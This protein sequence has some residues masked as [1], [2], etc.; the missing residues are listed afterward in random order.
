MP[1]VMTQDS[2]SEMSWFDE[3]FYGGIEVP[4]ERS[5]RNHHALTLL[6]S[7]PPGT[8]KSTLALEMC[9]GLITRPK[10][11]KIL[12]GQNFSE[13]DPDV[14]EDVSPTSGKI[15]YVAS[16]ARPEWMIENAHSFGWLGKT[17]AST[18]SD[19]T[20][21]EAVL[22]KR[23][24]Q[25]FNLDLRPHDGQI[26]LCPLSLAL[27]QNGNIF[28]SLR[29]VLGLPVQPHNGVAMDIS[30]L[31]VVV[32]DSLNTVGPNK[33]KAYE[34]AYSAFVASG[35]SL[36]IF[37]LDSTQAPSVAEAWEF[38]ADI[39]LRLDKD[40][41]SGYMVRTLEV[42]K[43]RYQSHV[44]GK[45]NLKIHESSTR[46]DKP[47]VKQ[48]GQELEK[49]LRAHPWM[50]G[51]IFVF[52][53][54]HYILSRFKRGAPEQPGKPAIETPLPDLT[55]LLGGGIP[56][57][58]TTALIGSRGGHKSHLGHMQALYNV[59]INHG[60]SIIVSL[61]D[62]EAVVK[63]ALEKY[64][65]QAKWAATEDA[66]KSHLNGYLENGQLEIL[67]YMPGYVTPEEF[68][69]RMLLSIFRMR[70]SDSKKS[71]VLIFNSLDQIASRFPLCAK[72]KVLIPGIIQTLSH[73]GV[74]SIFIGADEELADESIRNLLSMAELIIRMKRV[75]DFP[76]HKFVQILRNA[77]KVV[78]PLTT[79]SRKAE[80]LKL[81]HEKKYSITELTVERFAGGKPAGLQGMLEL[82][83]SQSIFTGI[84]LPG[85][86]FIPY[87]K[88]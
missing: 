59:E 71:I 48:T 68:F 11:I 55:A 76:H 66:A 41:G 22:K 19:Y 8:G 56:A 49:R 14:S 81:G 39:V 47:E 61:R 24:N 37:V 32:I 44:W 26:A 82:V 52:P 77:H 67:S 21:K 88:L 74:T 63:R 34:D 45:N 80:L 27:K 73:L 15:L 60:L 50:E 78:R 4:K 51:G 65:F 5:Q 83:T 69:H 20:K 6:I 54:I 35:P 16:E 86:H 42:V 13:E 58:Y 62:G 53:S 10:N 36:M 2:A 28:E 1:G 29:R 87:R 72:E 84:L 75:D 43:A 31:D 3:L 7:G 40:Y 23:A 25:L 12:R 85:L 30:G 9:I 64:I 33:A 46:E 70:H 17:P 18:D 57:G 79:A 38:G